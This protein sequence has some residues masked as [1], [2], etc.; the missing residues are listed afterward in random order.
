MYFESKLFRQT[1]AQ[2]HSA[3]A[4]C[5][6]C[7][8]SCFCRCN[9]SSSAALLALRAFC[10]WFFLRSH[11]W[12]F[13]ATFAS[14]SSIGS[15]LKPETAAGPKCVCVVPLGCVFKSP[16]QIAAPPLDHPCRWLCTHTPHEGHKKWMDRKSIHGREGIIHV[17]I[18]RAL[19]N[20]ADRLFSVEF[21]LIF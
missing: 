10:S 21:R 19:C 3:M 14:R 16:P 17:L 4:T 6:F 11:F 12:K 8:C 9:S 1:F 7:S 13:S 5:I 18:S 2:F 20:N 15:H